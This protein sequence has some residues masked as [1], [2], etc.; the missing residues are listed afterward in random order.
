MTRPFSVV[1][2]AF[3]AALAIVFLLSLGLWGEHCSILRAPDGN[4]AAASS[5]FAGISWIRRGGVRES[6]R[7]LQIGAAIEPGEAL[8]AELPDSLGRDLAHPLRLG[9]DPLHDR[10]QLARVDVPLVGGANQAGAELVAVEGA[11][12]AIPLDHLER[13][14]DGALIGGEAM[15]ALGA[16]PAAPHGAVRDS[17]GFER[18][19]GGGAPRTVH[20]V[21]VYRIL[22]FGNRNDDQKH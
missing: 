9:L 13:V 7:K 16:L 17:P 6:S 10:L 14:G 18:V 22:V 2:A 15:A 12:P 21:G 19:G 20:F 8:E 11:A 5:V 3:E 1:P 4:R